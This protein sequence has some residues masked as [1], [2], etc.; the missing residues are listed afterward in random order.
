M[1][2]IENIAKRSPRRA[3]GEMGPSATYLCKTKKIK[4]FSRGDLGALNANFAFSHRNIEILEVFP[5]IVKT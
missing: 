5:E 4:S 3:S 1:E 2:G